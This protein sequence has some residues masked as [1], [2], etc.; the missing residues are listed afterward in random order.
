MT[1]R[2]KPSWLAPLIEP[3]ARWAFR[4]ETRRRLAALSAALCGGQS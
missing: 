2:C 4:R 3:V 1:F